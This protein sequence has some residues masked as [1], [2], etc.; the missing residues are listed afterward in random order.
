M[1]TEQMLTDKAMIQGT[2]GMSDLRLDKISHIKY[3]IEYGIYNVT[4]DDIASK[5]LSELIADEFSTKYHY[6]LNSSP[7]PNE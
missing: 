2:D 1:I 6:E 3:A 5:M 4:S 7:M